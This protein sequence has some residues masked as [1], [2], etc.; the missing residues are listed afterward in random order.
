[1]MKEIKSSGHT[2]FYNCIQKAHVGFYKH[3]FKFKVVKRTL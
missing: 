3:V 2:D 1:M